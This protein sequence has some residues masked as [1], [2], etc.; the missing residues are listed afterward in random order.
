ME[1]GKALALQFFTNF[2]C[3]FARF[4]HG[5]NGKT[6]CT[7]FRVSTAAVAFANGGQIMP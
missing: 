7:H 4:G 3:G 2:G 5:A 1:V 6:D